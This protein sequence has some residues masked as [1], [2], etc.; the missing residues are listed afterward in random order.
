MTDNQINDIR[1]KKEFRQITLSGY[2]KSEVK[3]SLLQS[4]KNKK[5]ENSCYWS[6]ELICAGHIIDLWEIILFYMSNIIHLGNP[7]LPIYIELRFNNFKDILNKG[8]ID[9]E[10]KLRNNE[11]I[12]KLFCEIICILCYSKKYNTFDIPKLKFDDYNI[13]LIHNKLEANNIT[14]GQRILKK[15]D[16]KELFIAINEFAYNISTSIRNANNAFFWLEWLLNFESICNK[17]K[18]ETKIKLIAGRRN[19]PVDNNYQKETIWMI[20]EL[21]MYEA[22]KKSAGVFK[23]VQSIVNLF[24]MRFKPASIKKRRVLIYNAIFLITEKIDDNIPIYN[25]NIER[26]IK[27]VKDKS[28]LLFKEIKKNEVKPKTDYLFNNSINKN[29]EKTV[30]KLNKMDKLNNFIIRS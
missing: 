28:N 21:I 2:K 4:L 29:L 26:I 27:K 14:Y 11:K 8:Y 3:K 25:S 30:A 16:P 1:T 10:L 19:F 6:A 12:R 22:N 17:E 15:E 5:V 23:I 20:W 13:G 24:C 18:K 7:K 9:N